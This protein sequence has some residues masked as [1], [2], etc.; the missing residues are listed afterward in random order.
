[1]RISGVGHGSAAAETQ[2][3]ETKP[4]VLQTKITQLEGEVELLSKLEQE[5]RLVRQSK[6][7]FVSTRNKSTQRFNKPFQV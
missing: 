5:H 6:K 7:R 2:P 3:P 1:M 4:G